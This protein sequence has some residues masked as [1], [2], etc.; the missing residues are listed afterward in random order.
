MIKFIHVTDTDFRFVKRVVKS[1]LPIKMLIHYLLG[2]NKAEITRLIN[3]HS[4]WNSSHFQ[5]LFFVT[6]LFTQLKMYL[7]ILLNSLPAANVIAVLS[8]ET[9]NVICVMQHYQAVNLKVTTAW[10]IHT[11][12]F[13]ICF[14][15]FKNS[16]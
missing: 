13:W 11:K 15:V 3:K 8:F 9:I 6:L 7:V 16:I 4:S 12:R 1:S 5:Y 2:K 10:Y 14:E